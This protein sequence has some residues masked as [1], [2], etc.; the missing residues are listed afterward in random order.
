VSPADILVKGELK[1][2]QADGLIERVTALAGS[3]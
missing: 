2:P 3:Q 1:N